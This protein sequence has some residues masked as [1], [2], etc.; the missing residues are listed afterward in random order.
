MSTPDLK[1]LRILQLASPTLP[2][3]AFAYSQGLE[4][5]AANGLDTEANI[6]DWI[7]GVMGASL[8]RVDVPILARLHAAWE[9]GDQEALTHWTARLAASRE[10]AELRAEEGNTASA[11]ARLLRDLGLS[12]AGEWTARPERTYCLLLALAGAR[13]GLPVRDLI[14]AYLWAWAENQ[15]LAAI[16]TAPLGQTA[17]QRLLL[18]LAGHIEAATDTGLALGDQ[19]IGGAAPGQVLASMRH[20]TQGTRLFR[21]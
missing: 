12:E 3:G 20:E 19:D 15:V 10:T 1:L 2:V 11:L 16:K 7:A 18:A 9:R 17:G 4:W 14:R 13:W 21:S 8:A 5:A 6:L